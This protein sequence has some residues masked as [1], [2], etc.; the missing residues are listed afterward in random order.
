MTTKFIWGRLFVAT[1]LALL[2]FSTMTA[3]AQQN[4]A[5]LPVLRVTMNGSFTAGMSY[6]NGQMQLTGTD[7]SVVTLPAKF[8]TRGAT[9]SQYL[10]KPSFNMK[11]R[12]AD[13]S[14]EADTALLGMRSCS[15]FIVDAMAIDRICMRNRVAFDIWNDFSRLPYSSPFEG[16][17]G[18]EGRFVEVYINNT[19]YGIYCLSDRIN[20]KLLALSKVE[21][22]SGGAV[23]YHG[24]LYKSGT[25]DIANQNE[26]CYNDDYTACVVAW[27]D[28]WELT[29][30]DNYASAAV[31]APLQNAI[32]NG[33]TA[34]YVKKYFYLENLAD[35]QLHVMALC[36][37]DNWGNKN[38][39]LS[40][41]D[42]AADINSTD[43]QVAAQRKF[44]LTPWDLD[45]SL[46][47][48]YDGSYY[49]GNYADWAVAGVESNQLYP[50]SAVIN[51]AD[52]KTILRNRWKQARVSAF[53]T[54]SV[55]AKLDRY[56]NLFV[57]SGAWQ[58]MV[59]HFEAKSSKPLYVTDLSAEVAL[60][61]QWYA[62]RFQAMDTYFGLPDALNTTPSDNG[63][64][65][66]KRILDGT[67]YILMPDGTRYNAAGQKIHSQ[68]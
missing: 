40:V 3:Y 62:D 22:G 14:A 18:T 68:Q 23:T 48:A 31:W 21:E 49:N 46:G 45:T 58:R 20:R 57:Q 36:I 19:Y 29:Y 50:I 64:A 54:D 5:A 1:C 13:Y 34:D 52:Y 67:F 30:P 56:A 53:S 7:G 61:K 16:R 2:F 42:M 26:P 35:Y 59:D 44:I 41:R 38:H 39:F 9:A 43:P 4:T 15:S 11:I 51:D 6:I 25:Q 27:H 32:L 63:S 37:A 33:N 60:I 47:G 66:Q 65:P 17:N 28:A 8:K 55:N 10:M 12:T 24:A